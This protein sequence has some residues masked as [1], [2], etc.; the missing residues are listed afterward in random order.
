MNPCELWHRKF[1]HLNYRALPSLPDMVIGMPPINLIH[2]G[3]CKGCS[4]GKNVKKPYSSSSRRSKGI[5][6]PSHSDLCSPMIVPAMSG[7]LYY[8]I[9]VDDYSRKTYFIS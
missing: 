2:D 1:G 3:V 7:C 8:V 9:V 6:D 5:L 4:L